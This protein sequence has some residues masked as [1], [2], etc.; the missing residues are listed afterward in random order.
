MKKKKQVDIQGHRGC[1][2]LFPENTLSAFKKALELGVT[3]LE[4]DVVI[5]K[6]SQVVVS[7]EPWFNLEITTSPEGRELTESE[8]KAINIFQ[9]DYA[10]VLRYDVG[11]K[12]H[13]RF[14]NQFK[15]A[16][17]KPLLDEVILYSEEFC[18]ANK[19]PPICYNIEIKSSEEDEKKAYQP[20][21]SVFCN[22]V[23]KAIKRYHIE[24]RS[25]LQSFDVRVL[26]YLHRTYPSIALSY[27][28]ENNGDYAS[29]LQL[30][31]F[32]PHVYSCE[33]TLLTGAVVEDLH[34]RKMKVIPW[35]VNEP[36]DIKRM[37]NLDV[38]GIISDY[39]D[40]VIDIINE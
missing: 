12:M 15:K 36:E 1:R 29:A 8:G 34:K 5:S 35:T 4:L 16:E 10:S 23:M 18:L 38:D 2:G 27:L 30:L 17:H 25:T 24:Q 28:V 33:H 26:N 31:S 3:T 14:L 39:P 21:V 20:G 32:S 9:L 22:L 37:M 13:P 19:R 6:D 40:R 11:K 7:H